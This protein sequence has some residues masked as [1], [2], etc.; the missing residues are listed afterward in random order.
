MWR[1]SERCL[2]LS[3]L[4]FSAYSGCYLRRAVQRKRE[5]ETQKYTRSA[6]GTPAIKMP[7]IS[8]ELTE[9]V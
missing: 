3:I 4:F 5:K 7:H 8:V 9:I 2:W 6:L 1:R